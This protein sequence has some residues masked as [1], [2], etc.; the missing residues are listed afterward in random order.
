MVDWLIVDGELGIQGNDENDE[1]NYPDVHWV[2]K[3]VHEISG[4][5]KL[6]LNLIRE[7]AEL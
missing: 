3:Y 6:H 7:R 1:G 5:H 2:S 4:W